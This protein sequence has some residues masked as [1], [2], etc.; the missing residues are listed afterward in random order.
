MGEDNRPFM[1]LA[2]Q[3]FHSGSMYAV[4]LQLPTIFLLS[5][6]M[7]T[8]TDTFPHIQSIIYLTPTPHL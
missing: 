2:L 7:H 3:A 8:D 1:K 4:L 6:F 5:S